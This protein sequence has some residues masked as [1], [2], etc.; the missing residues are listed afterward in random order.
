MAH[1]SLASRQT[2]VAIAHRTIEEMWFFV[3]GQ[4]EM[5]RRTEGADDETVITVATGEAITI[6]SSTHFQFRSSGSEPL[7]AVGA[8]VPAWPGVGDLS[9]RGEAY[10]V[11]GP[12]TAT[13]DPGVEL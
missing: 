10:L 11:P 13:V 4:G 6:P 12:W 5:W 2:S 3:G 7:A 9:G 8:T 1:F